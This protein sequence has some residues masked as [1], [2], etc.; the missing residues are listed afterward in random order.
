M[1]LLRQF[2]VVFLIGIRSLPERRWTAL[3][4]VV[5]MACVVGVLLSM[6]SVTAGIMRA[7]L[8]GVDPA[9]VIVLARDS[10]CDCSDHILRSWV[11]TIADAPGIAK[12]P[13][14]TSLIDAGLTENLPPVEG[15]VSGS[16][17][18]RA[19]GARGLA[20]H[21]RL[22]VVAG[23]MFRSGAQEVVVGAAAAEG[24]GLKIGSTVSQPD[25]PWPV[26]GIFSDDGSLLESELIADADTVL[27]SSR[28]GGFGYVLVQL[29]SPAAFP[30]FRDWLTANPAINVTAELQR[31]YA[32]RRT[33]HSMEFFTQMSYVTSAIMA[34]GAIFGAV[35]I[36]YAAVRSR[37]R[38]IGT[39]RALGFGGA[40][41]ASSIVLE[42][43][44]L[45]IAGA[46]IGAAIAWTLFEGRKIYVSGVSRLH[47]PLTLVVLGL[48]WAMAVA[49]LSGL[50][51]ALRAARLPAVEA[52]RAE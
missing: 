43:A 1:S 9:R 51:P 21:P 37:T 24:F 39:L 45:S 18:L 28:R 23:R 48:A 27:A 36:M 22:R 20:L 10:D 29:T 5:G 46:L 49:L 30:M 26:V 47:V 25:G 50:F 16:L 8:R 41:V 52:L 33:S 17:N 11:G 42:T 3:V 6:L 7:S 12:S 44:L 31:E 15:F 32:I 35:K 13:D 19:F 14:G 2:C 4:I 40:S 38:E 34:L